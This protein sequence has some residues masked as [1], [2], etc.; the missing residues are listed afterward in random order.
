M[1]STKKED[2]KKKVEDEQPEEEQAIEE[3]TPIL[4]NF[5]EPAAEEKFRV[6][7]IYGNINEEKCSETL[8]SLLVLENSCASTTTDPDTGEEIVIKKPIDFYVSTFGGSATDMFALYDVMRRIRDD[9]PI[10]TIGIGKVM[11]AGVLLLAAGTK[12]ERRIG[13]NCRVMIHGV[14]AG[15]HGNLHDVENEFEEAK[16]TQKLYIKALAEETN[17]TEKYL[18]RLVARKTNVYI[19]ADEAVEL[20]IAD[21]VF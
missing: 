19:D 11:S 7:G 13:K 21:I 10:V 15:Q 6:T 12:G 3:A 1:F 14:I 20:G 17:M 2:K 16:M 18:K 5:P 9:C 8:Y 4:F